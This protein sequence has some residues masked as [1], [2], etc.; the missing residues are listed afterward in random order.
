MSIRIRSGNSPRAK[1]SPA[2]ASVAVSTIWPADCSSRA[3]RNMLSGLSSTIRIFATS[4]DHLASGHG[5]PDFGD[6][7]VAAELGLLDDR[8]D[9]T[10]QLGAILGGDL[11]GGD[12]QDR[13]AGR[14]GM[15]AERL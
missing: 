8:R 13:N 15:V 7:A 9:R 1:F 5:P 3:V 2:S 4:G 6:E 10:I 12:H 14:V 11:F